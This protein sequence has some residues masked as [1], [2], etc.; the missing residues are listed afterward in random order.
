MRAAPLAAAAE[1]VG[2][3]VQARNRGRPEKAEGGEE[4]RV[5]V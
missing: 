2:A 1:P 3:P 5:A 4:A